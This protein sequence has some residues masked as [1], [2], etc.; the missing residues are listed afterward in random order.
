MGIF[1]HLGFLLV[2][3]II[4]NVQSLSEEDLAEFKSILMT[5]PG[6]LASL[7]DVDFDHPISLKMMTVEHSKICTIFL[8]RILMPEF[9]SMRPSEVLGALKSDELKACQVIFRCRNV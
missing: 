4:A 9:C 1:S 6:C 5:C 8:G 7:K 2:I 3:S